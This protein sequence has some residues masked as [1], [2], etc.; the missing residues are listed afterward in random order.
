MALSPPAQH[1]SI[2]WWLFTTNDQVYSHFSTQSHTVG[3][4]MFIF[5]RNVISLT[6]TA[7]FIIKTTL[8]R[9]SFVRNKKHEKL[10]SIGRN[11]VTLVT[12]TGLN[13]P[14]RRGRGTSSS[15][16]TTFGWTLKPWRSAIDG[17]HRFGG[18]R[19]FGGRGWCFFFP[20]FPNKEYGEMFKRWWKDYVNPFL[21]KNT[22]I[23]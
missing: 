11:G 10:P 13:G 18:H 20:F 14:E 9:R 17:T 5:F 22:K 23:R 4:H 2:G 19:C 15:T 16:P 8:F 7:S 1:S 12:S 21:K 3:A 6:I